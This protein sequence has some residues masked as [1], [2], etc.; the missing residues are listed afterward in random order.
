ML[1]EKLKKVMAGKKDMPSHEKEAKM[2]VVKHLRDM[3][4][5]AMKDKMA[6]KHQVS[7]ASNSPEGL[8]AGLDVAQKVAGQ[9][10]QEDGYDD[11]GT[12]QAQA[13]STQ[14]GTQSAQDS[15]RK[16]FG[17]NKGGEIGQTDPDKPEHQSLDDQDEM[18]SE[19]ENPEHDALSA[20]EEHDPDEDMDEDELNAKL[21]KLMKMRDG[22]K[23]QKS[24]QP[25]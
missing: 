12:V 18:V 24:N 9:D 23:S 5:G 16:A 6:P 7:V 2:S 3:A 21:E 22:K 25:Y 11:G 1:D 13:S 17:Y 4:M 19:A 15:M 8:Q 14:S 10:G 20:H